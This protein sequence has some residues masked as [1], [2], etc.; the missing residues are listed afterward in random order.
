MKRQ[1]AGE[2]SGTIVRGSAS[3]PQRCLRS[4]ARGGHVAEH[5]LMPRRIQRLVAL[6]EQVRPARRES[7]RVSRSLLQCTGLAA[8]CKF[9][10]LVSRKRA[11]TADSCTRLGRNHGS[12]PATKARHWPWVYLW[13]GPGR[14]PSCHA[15]GSFRRGWPLLLRKRRHC[16]RCNWACASSGPYA[17]HS[18]F[19]DL[20]DQ[21]SEAPP[22]SASRVRR[23]NIKRRTL[24][25][26]NLRFD[27]G[28]QIHGARM[29]SQESAVSSRLGGDDL[30]RDIGQ[31]ER[32][33]TV[34]YRINVRKG[35]LVP[36]ILG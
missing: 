15:P 17:L 7:A 1:S 20:E 27:G 3:T 35:P 2:F 10:G 22:G 8:R 21:I 31:C 26:R 34:R 33:A 18:P 30:R 4:G 9:P 13:I 25:V 12:A 6:L 24:V 11:V 36:E 14:D 29:N 28:L 32:K 5:V 19:C 23:S 16:R